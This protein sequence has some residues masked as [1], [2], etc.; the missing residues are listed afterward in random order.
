VA[1]P[2][3]AAPLSVAT[4]ALVAPAAIEAGVHDSEE[5]VNAAV[6]GD[7][8]STTVL[9]TPLSV[10]VIEAPV[11]AVTLLAVA[12]NVAELAPAGTVTDGGVVRLALLLDS[13]TLAVAGA[14][15]VR[16]TVHDEEPGAVMETGAHET[17]LSAAEDAMAVIVPPFPVIG[18]AEPSAKAPSVLITP[19]FVLVSVDE[20]ANVT[21]ATTPFE[22][23]VVFIP[24]TTQRY[25]PE[26]LAQDRDFPAAVS[27]LP[28]AMFTTERSEGEY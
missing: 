2:D 28:A 26:P 16:V 6:G 4:Q 23:A 27:A 25:V 12:V 14:A 8:V 7:S 19:T 17:P 18:S 20:A 3:A 5:I 15:P 10:A 1:P 9:L 21:V 13:A 24:H 22:I 11:A